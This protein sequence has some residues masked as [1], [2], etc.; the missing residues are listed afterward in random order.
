MRKTFFALAIW[1]LAGASPAF[2]QCATQSSPAFPNPS[3]SV[4]GSIASVWKQYFAV[5]V[6]A[7]NGTLCNPTIVG[8]LNLTFNQIVAALGYIPLNPARNLSDVDNPAIALAN[9]GG[10]AAAGP[11]VNNQAMALATVAA[12]TVVE[13]CGYLAA[14]GGDAPCQ[15][16]NA[17]GTTCSLTTFTS[18]GS[19][20]AGTTLTIGTLASGVVRPG[21]VISS[22]GV[23]PGTVILSGSGNT[24]T[25]NISQNV[26]SGAINA[27]GDGA[28][29]IP[30]SGGGCF[31]A[32]YA[33]G[34]FD[35]REFGYTPDDTTDYVPYILAA[36]TSGVPLVS[37]P[38]GVYLLASANT[39]N[40]Y[41]PKFVGTGGNEYNQGAACPSPASQVHGTWYHRKSASTGFKPIT[42]TGSSLEGTGG[43]FNFSMCE[44]HSSPTANDQFGTTTAGSAIISGLSSTANLAVGMGVGG[45][46]A[47]SFTG[48]VSGTT[49]TVSGVAGTILVG[50]QL[51]GAGVGNTYILSGSGSTWT[52]NANLG[53]ISSE[54]MSTSGATTATFTGSISTTTLTVSGVTGTILERQFLVIPG[55]SAGVSITGGGPTVFTL[56]ANLGTIGSTAMSAQVPSYTQVQ[57]G[58][59]IASIDSG[60]QIHIQCPGP[61]LGSPSSCNSL[62][63]GTLY[64]SF[65]APTV[66]QP[67]FSVNNTTGR[68]IFGDVYVYNSYQFMEAVGFG[69]RLS[70]TG[71]IFGQPFKNFVTID[72]QEDSTRLD[73]SMIFWPVWS[74]NSAVQSWQV[75][76]G[77]PF[78]AERMDGLGATTFYNFGY[79]AGIDLTSSVNGSATGLSFANYGCDECLYGIHS[80]SNA[81][82]SFIQIG[83]AYLAGE[84]IL[85]SQAVRTDGVASIMI[86]N[87]RT[88]ATGGSALYLADNAGASLFV[89]TT[90]IVNYSQ[91]SIVSASPAVYVGTGNVLTLASPIETFGSNNTGAIT[92][93]D[94]GNFKAST[95][96]YPGGYLISVNGTTGCSGGLT[97]QK[98]G[99]TSYLFIHGSGTIASCSIAMPQASE[100]Q[101]AI[102]QS[103]VTISSLTLT[104]AS[105]DP[106]W[107]FVSCPSTLTPGN[108]IQA[109]WSNGV[110]STGPWTCY[111]GSAS[112][113]SGSI[114]INGTSCSLGGSCTPPAA[115]GT[116][117]GSTLASGVTASSLISFG[118]SP[119]LTSG[120]SPAATFG[121]QQMYPQFVF[122]QPSST[123]TQTRLEVSNATTSSKVDILGVTGTANSYFDLA[124]LDA[125]GV[126]LNSGSANTSLNIGAV[127]GPLNF[128]SSGGSASQFNFTQSGG[129]E[130]VSIINSGGGSGVFSQL[131][132]GT[133]GGSTRYLKLYVDDLS[134]KNHITSSS[135]ITAG[136]EIDVSTGPLAFQIDSGGAQPLTINGIA[137]V[138]CSGSPTSGFTTFLGIVTSC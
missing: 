80:R 49:L 100:G 99:P 30:G 5:K 53:T 48:S 33:P 73:G 88:L 86:S 124:V 117:T 128:V 64:L 76:N 105:G 40:T 109:Q 25:V 126:Y 96:N 19:S 114:T 91:D 102:I 23:T 121:V 138:S 77:T 113:A 7:N 15:Q 52:L 21:L 69:G 85:G 79:Y 136:L 42:I 47:A 58:A 93:W 132:L 75:S 18:T 65:W 122:A 110:S 120:G 27:P 116:L 9:L 35:I 22:A 135:G 32:V 131:T 28:T 36:A 82:G 71:Q 68:I 134:L 89:G 54:S 14:N 123:N 39:L 24:W 74:S 92:N 78:T 125:A 98:F 90:Q 8:L 107:P 31:N 16:Y 13:R 137:G 26:S 83:N 34:G 129:N 84:Q 97:M 43:F 20:I 106:P 2:A 12:R 1:L 37:Q 115:A 104:P 4:F 70:F 81:G 44:D 61:T 45:T 51:V 63:S 66:Y 38:D 119:T 46:T 101:N 59:T 29:Q 3:G 127:A 112:A 108:G 55:V 50:Q 11:F 67:T 95:L 111:A 103:D 6:D 56:S 130:Q 94:A 41:L 57:T 72:N 87:L 17:S 133:S 62:G 60:T 118:N 10:T